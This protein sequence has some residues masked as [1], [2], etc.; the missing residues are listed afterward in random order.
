MPTTRLVAFLRAINVGGHAVV[1]MADLKQ[2]FE[3][4]GCDNVQTYIA[5][6]NVL[7]DA[8]S[9]ASGQAKLFK[10]IQTKL[11]KLIGKETVIIY[12]TGDELQRLVK[13]NPFAKPDTSRDVKLYIAF[14]KD[15]PTKKPK[16]LLGPDKSGL[17]IIK[18]KDRDVCIISRP[19]GKGHYGVP[20][21]SV[22]T[23]F[24]V[25]ATSRNWNTVMKIVALLEK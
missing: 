12:R 20:N 4:A 21:I 19:I 7:F 3:D 17:E 9:T 6:G 14:L 5:S 25:P 11:N 16:L 13:A 2:A 15:K 10:S 1:K 23:G 24:G 22:E 8:P 18:L